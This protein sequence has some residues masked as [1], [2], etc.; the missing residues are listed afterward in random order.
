MIKTVSTDPIGKLLKALNSFPEINKGFKT[1]YGVSKR[2]LDKYP[3]S[4]IFEF[5]SILSYNKGEELLEQLNKIYLGDFYKDVANFKYKAFQFFIDCIEIKR[6]LENEYVAQKVLELIGQI[7]ADSF[8]LKYTK[9]IEPLIKDKPIIYQTKIKLLVMIPNNFNKLHLEMLKEFPSFPD[10]IID[11]YSYSKIKN[12]TDT[13]LK[14]ANE[15]NNIINSDDN[16][17]SCDNIENLRKELLSLKTIVKNNN[18]N[19]QKELKIVKDDNKTLFEKYDKLRE[20][21]YM[22][23]FRDSIKSFLDELMEAL[24]LFNYNLSISMKI[25]EIKTKMKNLCSGL[26]DTDKKCAIILVKILDHLKSL[27]KSGDDFSHYFNNI[28]FSVE[29][30]PEKVKKKYLV[31][32][33]GNENCNN[34]SLVVSSLNGLIPEAEEEVMNSFLKQIISRPKNKNSQENTKEIIESIKTYSNLLVA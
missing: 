7:N 5:I 11:F 24:N 19:L 21:L 16:I 18:T 17:E 26:N 4:V 13:F 23:N 30:L 28:G 22:I 34:A 15:K 8:I 10:S 20:Q 29:N 32:T 25:E 2:L 33:N 27:N 31:Y 12:N 6:H 9:M 1:L 14:I 3:N